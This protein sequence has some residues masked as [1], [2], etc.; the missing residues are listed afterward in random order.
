MICRGIGGGRCGFVQSMTVAPRKPELQ[1]CSKTVKRRVLATGEADVHCNFLI[2]RRR[3][4]Q[5]TDGED[6]FQRLLGTQRLA[7]RMKFESPLGQPFADRLG[8]RPVQKFGELVVATSHP[9]IQFRRDDDGFGPWG[10]SVYEGGGVLFGLEF[11]SEA[12]HERP[13]EVF[14][15]SGIVCHRSIKA[16]TMAA[17]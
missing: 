15:D 4:G 7:I 10:R 14:P 16:N 3:A 11:E 8:V 1:L 5:A 2:D 9:G 17:Q 12:A 13:A 6:G